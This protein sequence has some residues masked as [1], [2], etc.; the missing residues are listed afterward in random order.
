MASTSPPVSAWSDMNLISSLDPNYLHLFHFHPPLLEVDAAFTCS[1]RW[2]HAAL[3]SGSS[4]RHG[5]CHIIAH[6]CP[7]L[8]RLWRFHLLSVQCYVSREMIKAFGNWIGPIMDWN[9]FSDQTIWN[10]ESQCFVDTQ[11]LSPV[12]YIAPQWQWLSVKSLMA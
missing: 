3:T 5:G 10:Q 9:I 11:K 4:V 2:L 1:V 7:N 8:H 12:N 6:P